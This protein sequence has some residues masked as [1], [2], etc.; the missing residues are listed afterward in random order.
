MEISNNKVVQIH[1][2]GK[3]SDGTVFDSSEGKDALEFI[4]GSGMI[5]PGLEEGLEGL[6]TGDKKT[7]EIGF[8]KAYGPVQEQAKQEVPRA[9]LPKD[10]PLTVGMQLAA[11]GPQGQPMPVTVIELK[12]ETVVMDF[13]HPLAGKDLVFEVEVVEVREATKEELEH[14]HVHGPNG[15]EHSDNPELPES[16]SEVK[17]ALDS[18]K[19]ED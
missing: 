14:G 5:I 17:E 9:Q 6:K 16:E 11:Q 13:N 12:E 8:E 2:T 18:D 3:L 19:K 15:H 1:Y 4:F 10:I 7:V